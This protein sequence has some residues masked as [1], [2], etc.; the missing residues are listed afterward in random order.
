M[1]QNSAF[2][3]TSCS[4]SQ[5]PAPACAV[6]A[7]RREQVREPLEIERLGQVVDG[8]ELDRFDRAV[9]RG[10]AT[11]QN[12]LAVGIGLAYRAQH[13]DAADVGQ[14]QIDDGDIGTVISS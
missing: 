5:Q 10:V 2:F 7:H 1:P 9:D 11:H 13:L 12:D 3:A 6:V 4:A 14:A 8:A